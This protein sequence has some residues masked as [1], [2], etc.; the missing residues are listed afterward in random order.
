MKNVLVVCVCATY[1]FRCNVVATSK[2]RTNFLSVLLMEVR[3]LEITKLGC[4]LIALCSY[5]AACRSDGS[6]IIGVGRHA[7]LIVSYVWLFLYNQKKVQ[8]NEIN[9]R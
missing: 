9:V 1:K 4:T 8:K 5:Q 2:F 7:Y 6:R 3:K